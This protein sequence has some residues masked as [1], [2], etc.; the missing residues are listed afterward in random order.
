[1][2]LGV[3]RLQKPCQNECPLD[4]AH[5]YVINILEIAR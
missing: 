2:P 3:Q 4:D 1:M 5:W